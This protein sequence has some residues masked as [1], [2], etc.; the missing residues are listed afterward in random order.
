V[1]RQ[2]CTDAR[3]WP[4]VSLSVNVS[5]VQFKDACLAERIERILQETGF[6]CKRLQ[7]EITESALLSA[8][9][10]VLAVVE[11]LRKKGVT[12]A[13]DDFGTGYSS[14]TYL[15]RFPFD[16][17]KIDKSFI[18]DLGLTVNATIVHAIISIGRSLGL[19]LVAEGVEDAQQHKFL[20]AAGVH[21]FQGYLFGRP[22]SAAAMSDQLLAAGPLQRSA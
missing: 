13:L 4:G 22:M 9:E 18:D 15:R 20:A 2:A 21:H 1:L 11:R 12:I 5:A 3:A 10:A 7:L 19:K 14:L 17:I 16:K 6:D 8:E